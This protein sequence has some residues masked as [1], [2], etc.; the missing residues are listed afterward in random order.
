MKPVLD[1]L[2]RDRQSIAFAL[3]VTLS[4]HALANPDAGPPGQ[5]VDARVARVR[6][7]LAGELELTVEPSTLFDVALE[8]EAAVRIAAERARLLLW[9]DEL[10]AD[11]GPQLKGKPPP[12]TTPVTLAPDQL[13]AWRARAELDRARL[14]FYALPPE[15]RAELLAQHA[16]RVTAARAAD[17]EGERRVREAALEEER[18]R[19]AA[20]LAGSEAERLAAEELARLSALEGAI[21]T[22]RLGFEEQHK[23]L[24]SRR[25]ALLGWQ[26]RAR[27]ARAAGGA[28]ADATY[29]AV[30]AALRAS[31][32]ELARELEALD[33]SPSA[34]PQAA[35]PGELT[36]QLTE[37]LRP[38][39]AAASTALAAA[40]QEERALHEE[41]AA[42]LL[43]EINALNR[44]RLGLL[45][46]LSRDK[47]EAITG[48]SLTALEQAQ[49]EARHLLLTLRAHAQ[50]ARG[51]LSDARRAGVTALT[52]W[53][54]TAVVVPW[55]LVTVAFVWLRRRTPALLALAENRE[56][57]ADR[58]RRLTRPGV[59]RRSLAF[60]RNTH[61]PLEGLLFLGVLVWLIP[62]SARGLV[63]VQLLTVIATL[64]LVGAFVVDAVNALAA[65]A[66]GQAGVTSAQ[67]VLRL[68]SLRLVGRVVVGFTLALVICSRLV[69]EGTVFSWVLVACFLAAVPLFLVLVKWWRAAVFERL[70]RRQ[71]KSRLQSWVL[72]NR[73]GWKSFLAAM[74]GAVHLFATGALKLARIW[75]SGFALTRRGLAWLYKREI[76]RLA[77]EAPRSR[78]TPLSP[79]LFEKLSPERPSQGWI[80]GP[81]DEPLEALRARLGRGGVVALVSPNGGGK[82]SVLRRLLAGVEGAIT[83][84]CAGT[85]HAG[86]L[87]ERLG[88]ASPPLVVLDDAEALIKPLQGGLAQFDEV[89][90]L[91]RG[92]AGKTLWVFSLDDVLWPFLR[93]AR[94]SRPLFDEVL[95]LEPWNDEEIGALLRARS[96]EAGIDPVF[97]DL[98]EQLPAAADELDRLDALAERRAG[99]FRMTWDYARGNPAMALEA[100]RASLVQGPAGEVRVRPLVAPD[101]AVLERLP[102][103]ALFV[104]R[105][106][107]QLSPAL[108]PE[109]AAATR[110]PLLQ[111]KNALRIGQAQG[112]YVEE[113]AGVRVASP[114]LRSVMVH[115]ERRHLLVS[116]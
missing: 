26:R 96:A 3:C 21:A 32:D 24:L 60:L 77:E 40:L 28:E 113:P 41:R 86:E 4:A 104:L 88:E 22:A 103:Q 108:E 27:E 85:T 15:R 81:A 116:P 8:D 62:P 48:F 61:R 76:D 74:V 115:L 52:I 10:R 114:W 43:E 7:L 63:E 20:R 71:R 69:G 5:P 64:S 90:A 19:E 49:A 34:L 36:P 101:T 65:G 44:E 29:D 98:L 1:P 59:R 12:L 51:W 47:R 53:R 82:S 6:A 72:A 37:A 80:S 2:R 14:A 16:G 57:K 54:V 13:D 99:Y 9:A 46:E 75:V 30:R 92:S 33:G 105:A 87:K 68:R 79:Q 38:R 89:L 56:A 25:D 84:P 91:A 50:V 78:A 94:D 83:V 67:G 95:T 100:W 73:E 93:R 31:R 109:L 23:E 66:A 110:L 107:L 35:A 58:A 11:A 55:A 97:D 111:V 42:Q 112:Y 102:D 17:T 70:E 106:V 39:W 18:A 45:A